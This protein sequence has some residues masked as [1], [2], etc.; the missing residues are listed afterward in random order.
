MLDAGEK[1][2]RYLNNWYQPREKEFILSENDA[3]RQ[4]P[5][6]QKISGGP[7]LSTLYAA[8]RKVHPHQRQANNCLT[9]GQQ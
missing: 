1:Q 9:T 5:C 7:P 2:L 8:I 4:R 3:G 6:N